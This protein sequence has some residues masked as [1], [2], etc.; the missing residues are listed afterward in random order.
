MKDD[1]IEVKFIAKSDEQAQII[2]K[3][4]TKQPVSIK[5]PEA[6]AGVPVLAQ[7]GVGGGVGGVGGLG[8]QTGLGAGGLGGGAQALGGGFGG[9]L[10]GLG[11]GLGGGG[12]GG[13]FFNVAPEA[14]RRFSV[15]TVCLDHGK[16]DPTP[17]IPFEIKPIDEYVER[18]AVVEVVKAFARG[19]LERGAAQAATW[20]LNND[21]SWQELATK[22]MGERHPITRQRLP[23]FSA[24]EIR[25]A[26]A[27]SE[28][29]RKI[30]E[31]AEKAT[32]SYAAEY[33]PAAGK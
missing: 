14:T 2:L 16:P 27:A 25:V 12:F 17:R 1:V 28:H 18:P 22:T 4:N 7:I 3:N 31:S 8:G 21:V 13:G 29:A 11:G 26:M 6:F 5:L 23:W 20:H 24:L 30:A 15:D 32:D 19:E 33:Q 10:G 9:G